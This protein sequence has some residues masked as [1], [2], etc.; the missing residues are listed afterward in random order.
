MTGET[1][2]LRARAF[3]GEWFTVLAA[4]F[5]VLALAGGYA[6]GT[7]YATPDTETERQTVE[8]WAVSGDF[9][10]SATVTRENPV[11]PVGATL[12]D[13]ST[14]FVSATPVFDGTYT[15]SYSDA[16]AG[17]TGEP[18]E[19]AA[20]ATLVLQSASEDAVYWTDREQVA[21]TEATLADGESAT[22]SFSLNATRVD[23]RAADIQQ[24]LGDTGGEVSTSVVVD[25][26]ATGSVAGT[27][28]AVTASQSI[29]LR[30]GGST[31]SV[32]ET[33]TAREAATT[34]RTVEVT[35]SYGPSRTVGGPLLLV[36]GLAGLGALAVLRRRDAL[37][38]TAA[39]REYLAFRDDRAEFDEWV[40]R[41]RLPP[42]V[43]DRERADAESLADL[44]DY[45][46]DADVGVVEDTGTGSFYA[47]TR[48]V[49]VAF[50]P[51]AEPGAASPFA[52][53]DDE[54]ADTESLADLVGGDADDGANGEESG[55]GA[56]HRR[57][58]G[59]AREDGDAPTV[60]PED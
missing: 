22:L 31:Y 57:D 53:D 5:V 6:A 44:V 33:E 2:W 51:P 34:T 42:S 16:A 12:D 30:L 29:P 18:V 32:G 50:D 7:A 14:Y 43:H 25:V 35:Q 56:T 37:A 60:E 40:V 10:H 20:T 15:V 8:H 49:V 21:A 23:Q 24:A 3:A 36:A 28:R 41:A 39:E 46:I 26:N 48:E 54:D 27:E 52:A 59:D 47:V 38:L 58:A 55:D 4:A 1:R 17:G 19:M 9:Q 45:A 13:R 11:F